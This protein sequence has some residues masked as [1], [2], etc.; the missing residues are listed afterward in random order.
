MKFIIIVLIILLIAIPSV[1]KYLNYKANKKLKNKI[2]N[3]STRLRS[4]AILGEIQKLGFEKASLSKSLGKIIEVLKKNYQIDYCSIFLERSGELYIASTNVDS[5]YIKHLEVYGNKLIGEMKTYDAKIKAS[6]TYLE[7]TSAHDREVKYSYF[8]PLKIHDKGAAIL[9]ESKSQDKLKKAGLELQFFKIVI[10]TLS[11]V[12]QL[13]IDHDEL[14]R[15]AERDSMTGVYNRGYLD[16]RMFKSLKD[17]SK[18]SFVM[19]DI[20]HF[21]SF[22]DT[23][24]HQVGDIVL[25]KVSAYINSW[26]GSK[27]F[28]ARYGGEE[29]CIFFGEMSAGDAFKIVEDI[30][31]G[32]SKISFEKECGKIT[33]VTASFGISEFP[34][35]GRVVRD[36]IKAADKAVYFSKD[37]GRNKTTMYTDIRSLIIPEKQLSPNEEMKV[38]HTHDQK[39]FEGGNDVKRTNKR[40]IIS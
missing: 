22:N 34:A 3:L 37:S 25:T 36:I 31:E 1:M 12:I 20:D 13:L 38:Y 39:D 28:M 30:R 16:N 17:F 35:D 15:T 27:D 40:R 26:M 32:I 10:D 33:P 14:L 29:F 11:I 4:I 18:F 2:N 5:V 23:Y 19:I 21:K 24:G 7:Y 6:D 9:I 8:I